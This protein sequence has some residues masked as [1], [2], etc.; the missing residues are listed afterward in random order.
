[1][2]EP[3]VPPNTMTGIPKLGLEVDKSKSFSSFVYIAI[4]D[5]QDFTKHFGL[6]K[7]L[8]VVCGEEKVKLKELNPIDY[9]SY[10]LASNQMETG[11]LL[12]MFEIDL[13]ASK[14]QLGDC[15]ITTFQICRDK[16]CATTL[17][18]HPNMKLTDSKF[19]F[20]TTKAIKDETLFIG[21]MT[22]IGKLSLATKQFNFIVCG[23]E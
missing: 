17:E 10:A 3:K 6:A 12:E 7:G 20:D 18:T 13:Q 8:I 11:V 19:E 5:D 9:H 1:M 4:F 14:Q 22:A 21:A 15:P 16:L 23:F 2:E